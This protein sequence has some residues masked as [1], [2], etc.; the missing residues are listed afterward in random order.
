M[1]CTGSGAPGVKACGRRERVDRASVS[2]DRPRSSTV[3]LLVPRAYT[4]RKKWTARLSVGRGRRKS[5]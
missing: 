3:A 1:P 4:E 5:A 2:K